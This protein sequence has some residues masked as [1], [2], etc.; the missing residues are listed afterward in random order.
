MNTSLRYSRC[1]LAGALLVMP[2]LG[3][4]SIA[5]AERRPEGGPHMSAPREE[6]MRAP[7]GYPRMERPREL[8]NARP[9]FRD[10]YRHNFRADHAFRIGPYHPPIGYAYQRWHYGQILPRPY[11]VGDYILNDFWL[12]GLDMPPM[13]Y[14]WVRYGPDALLINTGTG[15]I[16]QVVYGRFF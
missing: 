11:W 8:G 5:S 16:V 15:E 4:I 6:P 2:L 13:G 3:G 1:L 14:E 12:F 9:A 7:W 10:E